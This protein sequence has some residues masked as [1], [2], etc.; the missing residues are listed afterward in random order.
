MLKTTKGQDPSLLSRRG[1]G[2]PTHKSNVTR[3]IAI[4]T[5]NLQ[6]IMLATPMSRDSGRSRS[7]RRSCHTVL[8]T[9]M[10]RDSE[11]SRLQGRC[12]IMLATPMS[13]DSE[14]LCSRGQ[15]R[16]T[17][18]SQQQGLEDWRRIVLSTPMSQDPERSRLREQ[19]HH[20]H[21]YC[22]CC[23][24]CRALPW[25]SQS[26]DLALAE[27]LCT[28]FC[29]REGSG[30]TIIKIWYKPPEGQARHKIWC[31]AILYSTS[32]VLLACL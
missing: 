16:K 21:L 26:P 9:P 18:S 24:H 6:D 14:R 11:R 13:Q 19:R 15:C 12:R 28:R 27:G 17:L 30:T 32:L 22:C 2:D 5:T 1:R 10:S 29:E 4:K 3:F 31:H 23:C 7:R 8:E 20:R 25:Q